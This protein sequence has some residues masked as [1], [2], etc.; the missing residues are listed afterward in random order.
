MAIYPRLN[1]VPREVWRNLFSSAQHEITLLDQAERSLATGYEVVKLLAERA[2]AGI[3]VRIC[4]GDSGDVEA[5]EHSALA[6]YA[7]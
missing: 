5:G 7:P 3:A 2:R 6:R 4:L 1:A